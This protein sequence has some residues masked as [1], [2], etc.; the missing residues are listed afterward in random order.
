MLSWWAASPT[1]LIIVLI[2]FPSIVSYC[3]HV[4]IL[5]GFFQV[6]AVIDD[7]VHLDCPQFLMV[8]RREN[9]ECMAI[10]A[11]LEKAVYCTYN[12]GAYLLK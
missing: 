3:A 5:H 10:S 9:R 1:I 6:P 8:K 4:G 2:S 7:A 12:D 11:K